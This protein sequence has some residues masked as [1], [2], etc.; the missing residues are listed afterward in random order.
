MSVARTIFKGIVLLEV[1][2][3]VGAYGVFHKMNSSQDFRY[4]MNRRFPSVL[5]SKYPFIFS[6]NCFL[7]GNCNVLTLVIFA[8]WAFWK[9]IAD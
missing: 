4:T 3:V 7:Y 9:S 5:E 2:G 1:A 6:S 8:A